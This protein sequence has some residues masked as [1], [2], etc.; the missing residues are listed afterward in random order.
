MTWPLKA[1]P[2]C[3]SRRRGTAYT[4]DGRIHVSS[5]GRL[6]TV[7]N[8]PIL[9]P[10][11]TSILVD[12]DKGPI[13]IGTDGTITQGTN[14]VGTIGMLRDSRRREADALR[15]C[16]G[17]S[18]SPGHGGA[19]TSNSNVHATGLCGGSN[20]DPILEMSRLITVQRAFESAASAISEQE[21]TSV[22]SIR[23]LGPQ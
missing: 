10:G 9:D 7:N 6:T 4:R 20:V 3:R 17:H 12:P 15:Q 18:R 11:G 23:S 19:G 2:G 21:T 16:R 22:D 1:R 13:K 8:Y 5:D 14:Q